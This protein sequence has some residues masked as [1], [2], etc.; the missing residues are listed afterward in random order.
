MNKEL[1][2]IELTIKDELKEGVFAISLVDKPAIEEDFIM[3]NALEVELKVINEEKREVVGLAL[4]PNKKI[5]RRKDNVEFY[6]E[7][8]ESTIEKVQELYLKNLRA[9]NVTIDHEKPVNGV[10]LI[11]SWIVEDPKN[12]KSNIYNLNAVKGAWVVKMKIYND[13]V[14]EGVKLG[15]FNGFSIEGM[16]DGLDQLKMSETDEREELI[17]E[18]KDLINEF[19]L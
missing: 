19:K 1:Q 12:D 14:Y 13:E 16:F 8:S 7:F 15:K 6:I 3:L 9:N 2:T 17:N 4:V 18:I 5:L 10:S 11:E